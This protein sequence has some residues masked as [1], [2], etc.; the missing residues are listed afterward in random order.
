MPQIDFAIH[1]GSA[2]TYPPRGD[3]VKP[4]SKDGDPRHELAEKIRPV[5]QDVRSRRLLIENEWLKSHDSWIGVQPYTFYESEF[6]HFIPAMRR[7][8]EKTV[9]RV[10]DQLMPHHEFYNIFPGDEKDVTADFAMVSLHRYMDWLLLDWL[11]IRR[12]IK[13]LV[14]TYLLYSRCIAK[15]TIRLYDIPQVE[16]GQVKGTIR[17]V[18]PHMRAVDPFSF[19]VW[20]ETASGIED[21]M[22][23]FEDIIMSYQ[24][25]QEAVKL[26]VAD[27]IPQVELTHPTWPFHVTQRLAR[28]GMTEPRPQVPFS[29]EK[30]LA[31]QAFVAITECYIKGAANR[32]IMG[33]FVW[34]LNE[35]RFTRLHMSR[36]PRP[37]YRMSVAR[38]LPTQHYTP[39]MGQDIE[40]LQVLLNDQFN[41]GEEARAVSSGPPVIVDPARTKRTDNF[42]FGYRRK[43]F[44]PV[45][46]VKMMDIPDTSPSALRAAMFTLSYMEG[47][48]PSPLMQGQT[49]RGMPRGSVAVSQLM[50]MAGADIVDM[51]KSIE[52]DTLTPSLQDLYDLTVGFVPD[53]QIIQIPGA[54]SYRPALM[55][56][57]ELYGGWRFKWAGAS[58][59]QDKQADAQQVQLFFQN[60]I[61]LGDQLRQQ[62]FKTD[63]ATL[64]RIMW[65]DILGERRLANIISPMTP[66][67]QQA[68]MQ[69]QMMMAQA[70]KSTNQ[71]PGPAQQAQP[72]GLQ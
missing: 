22:L 20:P 13:Q 50:S 5:L 71:Q 11:K 41:Q 59:F 18:W 6:R 26:G 47:S 62:G 23:V 7:T 64:V 55:T 21:A 14:R 28:V 9:V 16:Y 27:D 8:I 68:F 54:E 3:D 39:G 72:G 67:E 32:W 19:Y 37:P 34:N 43:W 17:M 52:D 4:S 46:A 15:N 38:E 53:T 12:V 24:E 35:P 30:S 44:A 57:A 56:V 61:R 48:G 25:Y 66:E 31:K 36:F 51:A 49:P 65:K 2:G 1:Q 70:Q 69:Q 29:D 33:W 45:D 63:W 40:A 60:L 10:V 42:I 58:R